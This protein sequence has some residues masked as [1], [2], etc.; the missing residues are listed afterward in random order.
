MALIQGQTRPSWNKMDNDS[1]KWSQQ[2]IDN[3][4]KQ[5]DI[6]QERRNVALE[7]GV[8]SHQIA[9]RLVERYTTFQ[10]Q[11]QDGSHSDEWPSYFLYRCQ[12]NRSRR[13]RLLHHNG[14]HRKRQGKPTQEVDL[15][16]QEKS[17]PTAR[18]AVPPPGACRVLLPWRDSHTQY[19]SN[20]RLS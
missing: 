10:S 11:I 17:L 5:L 19:V 3:Y 6:E 18:N 15:V 13:G 1:Q 8:M 20:D 4:I 9:Q 12:V 2:L 7:P 14:V 16:G